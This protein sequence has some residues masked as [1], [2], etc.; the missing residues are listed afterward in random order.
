MRTLHKGKDVWVLDTVWSWLRWVGV[1]L[2]VFGA[3]ALV[4]LD[5]HVELEER[6]TLMLFAVMMLA[7]GAIAASYRRRVILDRPA[8]RVQIVRAWLF[9][10]MRETLD[11]SG[12]IYVERWTSRSS[13]DGSSTRMFDVVSSGTAILR[14]SEHQ[15][16]ERDADRWAREIAEFL[17]TAHAKPRD[18][19]AER[20]R[21]KIEAKYALAPLLVVGATMAI[22]ALA[23]L[24]LG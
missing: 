10:P 1:G 12:P 16:D 20:R 6:R 13:E 15:G 24:F 7:G 18:S 9:L 2:I 17:D 3:A 23:F 8:R 4:Y 22:T 21:R 14:L 5:R 11:V 19:A